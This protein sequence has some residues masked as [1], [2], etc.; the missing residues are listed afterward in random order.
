M[1][2][3]HLRSTNVAMDAYS[4]TRPKA[5][6]AQAA[7]DFTTLSACLLLLQGTPYVP[8]KSTAHRWVTEYGIR[9]KKIRGQLALSWDDLLKAHAAYLRQHPELLGY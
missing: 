1:A 2:P 9:S 7:G 6:P 3:G 8:S 4:T 5:A